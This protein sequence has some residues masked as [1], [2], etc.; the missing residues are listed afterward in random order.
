MI[1][2]ECSR[3]IGQHLHNACTD[4]MKN[5]GSA[6]FSSSSPQRAQYGPSLPGPLCWISS[7]IIKVKQLSLKPPRPYKPSTPL[8]LSQRPS[9]ARLGRV[10]AA[11]PYDSHFVSN[12][13]YKS[14]LSRSRHNT[15]QSIAQRRWCAAHSHGSRGGIKQYTIQL[16]VMLGL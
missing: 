7:N 2:A 14:L 16:F 15:E 11:Q 13:L 4:P 8:Q 5:S 9:C 12:G 3:V 10:P 6:H 1:T